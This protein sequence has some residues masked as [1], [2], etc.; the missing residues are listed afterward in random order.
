MKLLHKLTG[1]TS[2]LNYWSC[3][4]LSKYLRSKVGIESPYALS[5]EEWED[6][7]FG[8]KFEHPVMY[9]V[10]ESALD[11]IHDI[12]LFPKDV[13]SNMYSKLH[14]IFIA[15]TQYL[16]TRLKRC[17]YYEI[18]YRMLHANFET[19]VDFV[20]VEK[21]GRWGW[22]HT[23]AS[24]REDGLAYLDWEIKE[25]Y[26]EQ[27]KDAQEIKELYLWWKD[28]YAFRPDIDWNNKNA[29]ESRESRYDFDTKQ[30][31]RLMR[32]RHALWS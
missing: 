8:Y 6:W 14:N 7:R 27:P 24:P 3:S 9:W 12:L 19:L 13:Y 32:I 2:R 5:M 20:E 17:Q 10:T 26:N 22:S 18:D 25:T 16:Q 28:E 29:Y 23:K 15:K 4:K 31:V 11:G 30:L 21:G 1:Y